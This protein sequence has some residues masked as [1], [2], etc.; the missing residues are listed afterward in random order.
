MKISYAITV[1]NELD[2]IKRLLE[3][4]LKYKRD[5][6]EIIILYDSH[7]STAVWQYLVKMSG[8]YHSLVSENFHGDFAKWKNELNSYCNGDYIFQ[9]DA[10]EYPHEN[11]IKSLPGI[12]NSNPEVD[13]FLVPRVNLVAGITDEYIQKWN[14]NQNEQGWI[15]FPDY[16]TRLYRNSDSICWYGNVHERIMG[17]LKYSNLP[18]SEEYSLFHPKTIDRQIKQNEYY[19]TL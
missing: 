2:E 14:W 15:N 9:I 6:D 19:D 13:L 4:L 5:E 1:C 18:P 8:T 12:I 17:A 16:Q 10:D 7:G 11:L 3:T